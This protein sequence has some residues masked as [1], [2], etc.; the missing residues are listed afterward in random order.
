MLLALSFLTEA[1][2]SVWHLHLRKLS[3]S[4]HK[5][6]KKILLAPAAFPQTT[7]LCF[8]KH[9]KS[10]IAALGFASPSE[11]LHCW[12]SNTAGFRGNDESLKCFGSL[13][14]A[15]KSHTAFRMGAVDP[16]V[17]SRRIEHQT[18]RKTRTRTERKGNPSA[19]SFQPS[20]TLR[21]VLGHQHPTDLSSHRGVKGAEDIR[22]AQMAADAQHHAASKAW[23]LWGLLVTTFQILAFNPS[24]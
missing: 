9:R 4:Q 13:E 2:S 19:G 5:R 14:T 18:T 6:K 10:V 15:G 20:Q 3:L 12:V 1:L 16:T 17:S 8:L 21:N 24:R 7:P 11:V 22:R 23:V